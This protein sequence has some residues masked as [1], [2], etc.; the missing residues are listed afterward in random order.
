MSTHEKP[1]IVTY[2]EFWPFYLQEHCQP[3]TRHLHVFGTG[4]AAF[5]LVLLAVSGNV[6][7]LPAAVVGGYGFAWAGH[8]FVERNRPATLRYPLWSL[9]SDCRLF[10]LWL[11]GRLK[12][13][14]RRYA[15]P[16]DGKN[17]V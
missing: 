3:G 11:A 8:F 1:V 14:Y 4:M 12:D 9:A 5:C 2:R 13:E 16:Y 17:S 6:W 10:G 7:W 15:V